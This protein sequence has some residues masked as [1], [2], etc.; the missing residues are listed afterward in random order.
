MRSKVAELFMIIDRGIL[1]RIGR[2]LEIK[3]DQ[4]VEGDEAGAVA[5]MIEVQAENLSTKAVIVQIGFKIEDG[6]QEL[7]ECLTKVIREGIET[8]TQAVVVHTKILDDHISEIVATRQTEVERFV[9]QG[10]AVEVIVALKVAAHAQHLVKP[11]EVSHLF[12]DQEDQDLAQEANRYRLSD[13]VEIDLPHTQEVHHLVIV[14]TEREA[15]PGAIL[16]HLSNHPEQVLLSVVDDDKGQEAFQEL[17][18]S[19]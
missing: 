10:I 17:F 9:V 4:E 13:D 12:Y 6:A 5:L 15:V 2:P 8:S 16:H 3:A 7:V 18:A 14:S 11:I 19:Y 1:F